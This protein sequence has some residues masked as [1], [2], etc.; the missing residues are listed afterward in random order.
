MISKKDPFT[1]KIIDFGLSRTFNQGETQGEVL[2]ET[3]DDSQNTGKRR[4]TRAVLKTKAGTPFY[5][6]PEVLTGNYN[7]KCDVWSAGVILYILFCGYPPFYGESNRQILESVKKGKLDFSSIEWKD[8]SKNAIEIVKKMI[9]HHEKRP[10]ADEV[11]K[12][13]WMFMSKVKQTYKEKVKVLYHNQK[14]YAKLDKM[15]QLILY[16][17]VRNLSEEDIAHYHN[18]FDMFDK[19]NQGIITKENFV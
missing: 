3:Q 16:Y 11:L 12:N 2:Q 15:R 8:K 14:K 9:S 13:D 19:Q 17:L 18:Y 1:L 4:K 10:F 6:A 7:E 5:I